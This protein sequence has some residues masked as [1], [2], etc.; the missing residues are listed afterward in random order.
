MK[1]DDATTPPEGTG[2]EI[3]GRRRRSRRTRSA[4]AGAA[5]ELFVARG[6]GSTTMTAIADRAGVAVQTVYATYT[7]KRAILADAL[8]RAIAGDD[9]QVVVNDRDWMHD[10]WHAPTAEQRLTAYAAAVSRIMTNAGDMFNVVA[11]AA[12]TD[13][14]VAELAAIAEARRRVGASSVVDSIRKVGTL[15]DG[16]GRSDAIDVIWLLN[17]PQTFHHFVRQAGWGLGRYQ[18]WLT[19]TMITLLLDDGSTARS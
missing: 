3:D 4:I 11:A 7:T 15:R 8:D 18:R 16:L 6:Y 19:E 14:D 17:G 5:T 2:D 1:A 9:E 12:A 13:P 10:V